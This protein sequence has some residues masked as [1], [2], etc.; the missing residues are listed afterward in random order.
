[1]SRKRGKASKEERSVIQGERIRVENP[2]YFSCL[3]LMGY[4]PHTELGTVLNAKVPMVHL[5]IEEEPT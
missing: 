1:M 4:T 3:P 2:G 5:E